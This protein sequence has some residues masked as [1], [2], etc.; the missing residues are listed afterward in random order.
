MAKNMVFSMIELSYDIGDIEQYSNIFNKQFNIFKNLNKNEKLV[1]ENDVLQ[2]DGSY[3][4]IQPVTRW[5]GNQSRDN[6]LEHL[7]K[8]FLEYTTFLNMIL[9]ANLKHSENEKLKTITQTNIQLINQMNVGFRNLQETYNSDNTFYDE[10][11]EFL[12]KIGLFINHF[13]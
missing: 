13:E 11:N 7:K 5:L 6:T 2:K 3:Y 9:Q 1:I 12:I 4:L 8:L 10:I